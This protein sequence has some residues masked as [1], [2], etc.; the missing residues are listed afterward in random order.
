MAR[1][2]QKKL[3]QIIQERGARLSLKVIWAIIGVGGALWLALLAAVVVILAPDIEGMLAAAPA[4]TS[5]CAGPSLILAG[6]R[7]PIRGLAQA[8]D[9]SY[10]NP[11]EEQAESAYWYQGNSS[12]FVFSLGP[13]PSNLALGSLLKAGDLASI[14]DANCAITSFTLDA[15]EMGSTFNPAQP[16]QVRAGILLFIRNAPAGAGFVVRGSLVPKKPI[17]TA[18]PSPNGQEPEAEITLLESAAVPGRIHL[19]V[20]VS[21]W[22]TG[23]NPF[24]VS[25]GDVQLIA[26]DNEQLELVQA[27]PALPARVNAGETQEFTFI[28]PR[29][30]LATVVFKIFDVEYD[31]TGY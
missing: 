9:G 16:A 13:S 7:F 20:R 27:T 19:R 5:R 25:A 8:E 22:N 17:Y 2:P 15:P 12:S 24:T 18:T 10:Q 23:A 30:T 4:P 6:S 29:P 14:M 11:A 1:K 3:I 21:V 28:F 26:Q 31:I